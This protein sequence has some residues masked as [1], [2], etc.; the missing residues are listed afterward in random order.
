ME[1]IKSYSRAEQQPQEIIQ[2]NITKLK[3]KAE[4]LLSIY[5]GTD[6]LLLKKYQETLRDI[7]VLEAE[8]TTQYSPDVKI[9]K[10]MIGAFID[11]I[12]RPAKLTGQHLKEFFEA[13]D[14]TLQ[15]DSDRITIKTALKIHSFVVALILTAQRSEKA[16]YDLKYKLTSFHIQH[17]SV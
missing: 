13:C 10:E 7:K 4:G 14:V 15:I 3:K 5:D 11:K 17:T 8:L 6:T 9:T 2:K 16:V 12:V 1:A